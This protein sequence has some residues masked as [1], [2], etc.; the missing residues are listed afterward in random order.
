MLMIIIIKQEITI[1][2]SLKQRLEFIWEF[3]HT[4]PTFING[5]IHKADKTNL[6]YLEPQK[7]IIKGIT[8]L[9]FNNSYLW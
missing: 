6:S 1:E 3:S 9:T 8:F 4:T 5:F 7:I 2:E